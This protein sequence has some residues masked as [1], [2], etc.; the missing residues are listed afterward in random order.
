[1][2]NELKL[3]V[4]VGSENAFHVTSTIVTG[5]R[6]AVVIDAQ[7][8]R[9]DARRL[10]ARIKALGKNLTTVYITHGHPDHYLGLTTL[11]EEFPDA[12][13]VTA[14]EVVGEIEDTVAAKVA[15]WKP[16]YGDEVPGEP[17]LPQRLNSDVIDVEGTELQVIHIGQGDAHD[18]TIVSIP[19][20]STIVAGDVA[21]NGTHVW[22]A[23]TDAEARSQWIANLEALAEMNL[24]KVIAGH[25]VPD[26]DDDGRRV[27]LT[28]TR[29]YVAAFD[30]AVARTSNEEELIKAVTEQYGSRAL[31][32][33]LEIA[34]QATFAVGH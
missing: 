3:E 20:L 21:Y 31:P 34:A 33:I 22:L 26:A 1:M 30:A 2:G 10:A 16:L 5:E 12:R 8:T 18:S 27:L 14:P 32:M 15:Q 9:T 7:F 6:D 17:V 25:K 19:T 11:R 29:D 23:E 4:F 24:A 28:E 13:L